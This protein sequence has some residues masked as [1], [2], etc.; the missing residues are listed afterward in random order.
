MLCKASVNSRGHLGASLFS[1]RAPVKTKSV[2]A[3]VVRKVLLVLV[4]LSICSHKS[5]VRLTSHQLGQQQ[6]QQLEQQSEQQQ[7]RQLEQQ[8]VQQQVQQLE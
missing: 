8:L 5:L 3:S 4:A 7:V 2:L 6:V 1:E